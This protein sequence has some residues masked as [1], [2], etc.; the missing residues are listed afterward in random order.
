MVTSRNR[1]VILAGCTLAVTTLGAITGAY[2]LKYFNAKSHGQG[3]QPSAARFVDRFE[4]VSGKHAGFRRNHAKGICV[5]GYFDS[6]GQAAA[7]SRASL[8]EAGRAGVVGR[9]SI[10][11]GDPASVDASSRVRSL[12]LSVKPRDGGEWRTAM[13]SAPVFPVRTPEA[14][15]E[16]LAALRPGDGDTKYGGT[17]I[18][19]FEK[20]H[21]ETAAFDAWLRDHPPSSGYENA[22]YYSV[23]AFRLVDR[24]GE[25]RNVRWSFVPEARYVPLSSEAT[26]DPD[27]LERGLVAQLRHGPIRWHLMLTLAQPGDPTNDAT[28]LWPADRTQ[29]DA[30]TLVVDAAAPQIDGPCRDIDFNPLTLPDGMAPSDDPLLAARESAYKESH[31]RR[32]SE[33]ARFARGK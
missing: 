20:T 17:R 19:A 1:I 18:E 4:D 30:G 10:V 31:E 27:F 32:T 21:P 14:L 13:N 25:S 7:L 8:F 24:S 12:A 2:A 15:F 26:D 28:R 6:N 16:L 29:I 22:A 33:Q 11:G 9:M 5:T 23:S 3:A